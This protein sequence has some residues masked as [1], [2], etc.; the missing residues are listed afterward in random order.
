M[1]WAN[2]QDW[3]PKGRSKPILNA[4]RTSSISAPSPRSVYSLPTF[5]AVGSRGT[6]VIPESLHC[7]LYMPFTARQTQALS[8]RTS[9]RDPFLPSTFCQC[10]ALLPRHL[11]LILPGCNACTILGTEGEQKRFCVLKFTPRSSTDRCSVANRS[12]SSYQVLI[13][14]VSCY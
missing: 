7:S 1:C 3:H 5:S 6:V 13:T 14:Q 11:L 9:L 8:Q 2:S 12:A 10:L 4:G